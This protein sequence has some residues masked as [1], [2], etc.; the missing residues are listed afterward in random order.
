MESSL[1]SMHLLRKYQS[2]QHS[3]KKKIG[4]KMKKTFRSRQEK[5]KNMFLLLLLTALL[6]SQFHIE[7]SVWIRRRSSNF[8]EYI[9]NQ[10]F[11]EQD[12]YDNFRMRKET[13]NYLCN[14]LRVHI[15][16]KDTQLRRAI[17]VELRL[18]ITIWFLASGCGFRSLGHLFGVSKASVCCI[19]KQVTVA[20]VKVL[21]KRYIKFPTGSELNDIINGFKEKCG[22]PNCCGAIDGCHI[23]VAA[24]VEFHSDYYNRKGWFSVILQ[25]VADHKYRFID[26][27]TGWP[28]SVH[29][30][31]V[32]ANSP[33][34][35]RG[36]EK[37]LF[38][39]RV[40][41]VRDKHIPIVLLGDS[42]YP[43]LSW[44]MKPF[45]HNCALSD[46]QKL[47]NYHLSK[48]RIVIE[49]AYGRL[50]ARWRCLKKGLD[51]KP[52]NATIII[53]AC[54]VLHNVCEV[55]GEIFDSL[56]LDG[57][58]EVSNQVSDIT[59]ASEETGASLI[60]DILV[61]Y[62]VSNRSHE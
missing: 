59:Y 17:P 38:S 31:R 16:K 56:W 14:Q 35:K 32:F 11:T 19:V 36:T 20:I 6:T 58:P 7:R 34:Y 50:K 24:P 45:P 28:G 13:F 18:A 12:W 10:T 8:W 23:P 54:C 52:E 29:D 60:R 27:Y 9:V 40:E 2:I 43:L 51:V 48:A 30:A 25:G 4:G 46:S 39:N 42:A 22:F 26:I 62:F 21:L 61:N 49:N 41:L 57:D 33:I 5:Q 53:S 3:R 37:S 47:Y 55:H 1:L 44:V 15:E